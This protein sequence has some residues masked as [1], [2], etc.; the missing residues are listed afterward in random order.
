M[1]FT[2][3]KKRMLHAIDQL[4]DDATVLD[5]IDQLLLLYRIQKGLNQRGGIS[6]KKIERK[7]LEKRNKPDPDEPLE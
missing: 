5:A 4:P 2:I 6:Q 3:N 1:E 7:F